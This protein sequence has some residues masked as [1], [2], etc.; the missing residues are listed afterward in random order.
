MQSRDCHVRRVYRAGTGD[1]FDTSA[2]AFAL[3]LFRASSNG[4][5][6]FSGRLHGRSD[7]VRASRG[8]LLN[9]ED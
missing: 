8:R 1:E 5:L 7:F 6:L 2:A 9:F 3:T 4:A